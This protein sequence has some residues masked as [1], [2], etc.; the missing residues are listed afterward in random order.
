M[1][2]PRDAWIDKTDLEQS[3]QD[4][5]YF[6]KFICGYDLEI[7]PHREVC[8]FLM[9]DHPKKL[10]LL[11][12]N[13]YKT[14]VTSQAYVAWRIS[15]NPDKRILLDSEVLGN[16]ERNLDVIKNI[17]DHNQKYRNLFGEMHNSDKWSKSEIIVDQRTNYLL[18][19][20]SIGTASIDTIQIGPHWDEIIAD[21]LHSEKNTQTKDQMEGVYN[22]FKALHSLADQKACNFMFIGTRWDESDLYGRIIDD[23]PEYKVFIASAVTNEKELDD[24]LAEF[25]FPSVLNR[26]KLQE[27]RRTLGPDLYNSQYNNDP[28]PRGASAKFRKEWFRYIDKIPDGL[29]LFILVDPAA[30]GADRFALVVVGMDKANNLYVVDYIILRQ[31]LPSDVAQ[32]VMKL[33]MKYPAAKNLGVESNSFQKIYK[34]AFEA[35]M[36]EVWR[37]MRVHEIKHYGQSKFSRI[38]GLQPLYEQGCVYHMKWMK[39][40]EYEEEL[41]K[42]PKGKYKDLIDAASFILDIVTPYA[43]KRA[44]KEDIT[45]EQRAML[46]KARNPYAEYLR[47]NRWKKIVRS[48]GELGE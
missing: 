12:R 6:A 10:M 38:M 48:G 18:K 7:E 23:H 5:Y 46:E 31:W 30:E 1:Q 42:F 20:P 14:S 32:S 41:I 37:F 44:L 9:L 17:F 22:H 35:K 16:S 4:V 11:P 13:T 21:D 43:R 8:D 45:P 26:E 29:K 15:Q 27:L 39:G 24:P 3:L 47:M 36:K 40:R 2:T 34:Y 19:E 28:I 25:F 33:A